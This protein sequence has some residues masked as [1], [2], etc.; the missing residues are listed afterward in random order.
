[1]RVRGAAILNPT[2]LPMIQR[3]VLTCPH[4]SINENHLTP[5]RTS[6]T[7]SP[8]PK[9]CYAQ[10]D[11]RPVYNVVLPMAE[12]PRLDLKSAAMKKLGVQEIPE[13]EP[14]AGPPGPPGDSGAPGPSGPPGETGPV[15]PPGMRCFRIEVASKV[16]ESGIMF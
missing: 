13:P 5:P 9:T 1:M 2:F 8:H 11:K 10:S 16:K 4:H 15:G 6:P 14:P 12:M 7:P 3:H